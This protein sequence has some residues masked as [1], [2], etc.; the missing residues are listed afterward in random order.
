M[1]RHTFTRGCGPACFSRLL[2]FT[3]TFHVD[4]ASLSEFTTVFALSDRPAF[5][6]DFEKGAVGVA[7]R[8][9]TM[10]LDAGL[11]TRIYQHTVCRTEGMHPPSVFLAADEDLEV[12]RCFRYCPT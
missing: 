12:R 2:A 6:F 8:R 11:T 10:T 1:H 3:D 4:L 5:L 9:G 7:T